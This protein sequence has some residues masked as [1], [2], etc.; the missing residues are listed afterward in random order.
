MAPE[1]VRQTAADGTVEVVKTTDAMLE[2]V[3]ALRRQR[4]LA[5]MQCELIAESFPSMRS[6]MED[7][8][9]L[10]RVP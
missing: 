1:W 10:I 4:L 3:S 9:E 5:V 6:V 8:A 7:L 2:Y